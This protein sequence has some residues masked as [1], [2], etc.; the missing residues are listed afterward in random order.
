MLTKEKISKP[1]IIP[2][3]LG[4]FS[5]V[6][7]INCIWLSIYYRLETFE[8]S[9]EAMI[10][11]IVVGSVVFIFGLFFLIKAFYEKVFIIGKNLGITRIFKKTKQYDLTNVDHYSL[12]KNSKDKIIKIDYFNK[13]E[14][15]LFSTNYKNKDIAKY[16]D[17]NNIKN[18]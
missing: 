3:A 17:N 7:G 13:K 12:V 5:I 6:F 9:F 14:I 2:F 10:L 1:N 16:L 15:L 11:F 18:K 4:I 8:L